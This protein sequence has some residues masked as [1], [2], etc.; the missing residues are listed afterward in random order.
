L[1]NVEM[2]LLLQGGRMRKAGLWPLLPL[3]AIYKTSGYLQLIFLRFTY[4]ENGSKE[5]YS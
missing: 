2:M 4:Y 3:V 1:Q 5:S